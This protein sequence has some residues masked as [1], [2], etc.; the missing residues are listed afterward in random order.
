MTPGHD[1]RDRAAF[2]LIELLVVIAIIG[3]LIALLLP[4]VQAAREAARRSQCVNNLMQIG[5]ALRNY[6]SA[7]EVLP[8]GVV[9]PAGPIVEK[10]VGYQFG[11]TAQVL[12]Y[13]EGRNVHDHLNFEFGAY[14]PANATSRAVV[15]AV[16]LCPSDIGPSQTTPGT[17][18]IDFSGS[19]AGE[20]IPN[21]PDGT[22]APAILCGQSSY[23]A[24]HNDVEAPIASDNAGV[25]F[26]NSAV[27]SDD[28]RDGLSRTIFAGEK[29]R[30]GD[31][32][33]ISGTRA[34]LRN[35]GTPINARTTPAGA[36]GGYGSLHPGGANIAFGDGS[37]RLLKAAIDPKVYRM[38]GARADGGVFND[39]F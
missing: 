31:L 30:T 39:D 11:W 15:L 20:A 33:W 27:A 10:P 25:F 16:L 1:N 21:S 29:T 12:P 7:H 22:P 36:V 32:G 14:H 5:I 37:V 26:L 38:L 13:M 28:V 3:V 18:G 8:P 4:A 24:C 23:A 34:T 17:I 35:T 9:N 6:E 19:E 2:T